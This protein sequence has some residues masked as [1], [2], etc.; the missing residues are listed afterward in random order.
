MSGAPREDPRSEYEA[1]LEARRAEAARWAQRGRAIAN[2]RLVV[3]G[4][5]A[6][7]AWWVLASGA[8][9]RAWLLLPV[10]AF[11]GLVI[12]HDRARLAR[13]RA[14]RAAAYYAGG[15]ARI[16]CRFAGSGRSGERFADPSHPYASHLDLFGRGSLFERLSRAQTRAGEETLARWL[17]EAAGVDE[18]RARQEAL[19]ELRPRLDLRERQ[20]VVG[21]EVR[22]GIDPERLIAWGAAKRLRSLS[23]L[24]WTAASVVALSLLGA[25]LA[26]WTGVGLAPLLAALGIQGVFALAVR[27]RVQRVMRDAL[28]PVRELCVFAK[29]L[30]GLE[31]ESF[32]SAQLRELSAALRVS[33]ELPSRQIAR[34]ARLVDLLD[35]RRNQLFAPLAALLLWSSQLAFAIEAWRRVC[36]AELACWL[37]VTGSLEALLDLAGYTFE[38][39]GDAFPELVEAGP[40]FEGT[41]LGHPLLLESRCVRNDVSLSHELALLVVSGS[42]MSGKSTLLRTVGTNAVLALAGAPVRATRLRI[43]PLGLGASLRV[44]D[45]LQ[46]GT[47]R[48]Y[49]EIRGLHTVVELCDEPRPVLFLFD[50]ILQGTNS[51]DRRI[52]AAALARGLIERGAIGLIT[53]HDLALAKIVDELAPRARNVHFEDQLVNG[54]MHFDYRLR[55]GVIQKSNALAL[56]RSVGLDV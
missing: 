56:M 42:N 6:A 22:A 46:E 3:F 37:E 32:E 50:E 55:E 12:A 34:L 24:R 18:I 33:Q 16:D 53:T 31:R 43:S 15:L 41:G 45:S 48:F 25:G 2:A 1:R 38:C 36:G 14:Q 13:E 27:T 29:L 5:G 4:A 35:A 9:A 21:P 26:F 7:L 39:P 44:Q 47:S 49:A 52:G 28:E 19:A 20:A 17:C 51:H 30:E 54:E 10:A 23:S 8:M 11:V 40:I